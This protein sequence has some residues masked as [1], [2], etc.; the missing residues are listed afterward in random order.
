MKLLYIFASFLL[1]TIS[2]ADSPLTSTYFAQDYAT[3]KIVIHV[4]DHGLDQ[5]ALEYLANEKGN[6]VIKIAMINQLGWGKADL[7]VTFENHLLKKRKGLKALA[8]Q[9]LKS[10]EST[11]N[12]LKVVWKSLTADDLMCW[13][14][15]QAMGDYFRPALADNAAT[16]AHYKMKKSMAHAAVFALIRC[17]I[18]F[19]ESWCQ[20]YKIG[21]EIFEE[22]QYSDNQLSNSAVNHIMEYLNLYHGDC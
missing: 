2:F 20:V 19:D 21:A 22:S 16:L 15:L 8:F 7:V 17:Q 18:A 3:E 6:P 13:A 5:A 1:T 4:K 12:E 11:E 14:Y 10:S 9:I